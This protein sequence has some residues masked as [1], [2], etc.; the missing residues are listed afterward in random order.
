MGTVA[1]YMPSRRVSA[2]LRGIGGGQ[3]WYMGIY[4]VTMTG[5]LL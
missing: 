4:F 1:A 3:A 5:G 2:G